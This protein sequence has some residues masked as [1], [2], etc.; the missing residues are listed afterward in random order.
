MSPKTQLKKN[1]IAA[2]S[3]ARARDVLRREMLRPTVTRAARV[4]LGDDVYA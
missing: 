3:R 2:A 1:K 4:A